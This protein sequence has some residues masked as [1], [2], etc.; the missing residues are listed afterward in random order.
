MW[1][2]SLIH[3]V[4]RLFLCSRYFFHI[5]FHV[6]SIVEKIANKCFNHNLFAFF[7]THFFSG[8]WF[9]CERMDRFDFNVYHLLRHTGYDFITILLIDCPFQ[10]QHV[11]KKIGIATEILFV[12]LTDKK[13]LTDAKTIVG[14]WSTL[15]ISQQ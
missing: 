7:R 10:Y 2:G 5:S 1:K 9:P 11:H 6:Q 3:W 8:G 14:N 13:K 15:S 4:Y 12:F